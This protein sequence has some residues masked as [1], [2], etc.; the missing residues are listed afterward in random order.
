MKRKYNLILTLSLFL[1]FALIVFVIGPLK[2]TVNNDYVLAET[3][4]PTVL[5]FGLLFLQ[6]A[7]YIIAYSVIFYCA[8]RL[9][10][11]KVKGMLFI[12]LGALVFFYGGNALM[13]YIFD[14]TFDPVMLIYVG[15]SFGLEIILHGAVLGFG[16]WTLS[17]S[18]EKLLPFN[19]LFSFSN[20]LQR[21]IAVSA[22]IL[23]ASKIVS[24]I[25]YD[26]QIG[27]PESQEETVE[28]LIYYASDILVGAVTL[29]AMTYIILS[30]YSKDLKKEKANA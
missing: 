25:I 18:E 14:H 1:I 5:E 6:I 27:A 4:L 15:Q 17:D 30:F 11:E 22:L 24:R 20:P 8:A 23:S 28:M 12:F 19:K 9:G 13:S 21:V 29:F 2:I 7:A 10:T 3:P 16:L 26:V